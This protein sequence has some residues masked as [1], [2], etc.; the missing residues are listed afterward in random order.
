MQKIPLI[1][2]LMMM[3]VSLSG[4][5][6]GEVETS[7]GEELI[8]EDTDD[9]PTYYVPTS[10]DLPTCDSTTLGR[11]YYVEAETNFQACSSSGWSFNANGFFWI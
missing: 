1:I 4:C 9:W 7:D 5:I 3:A 6:G 10:G 8:L 2:F 11:L